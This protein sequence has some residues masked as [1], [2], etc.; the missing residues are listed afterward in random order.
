[1][2]ANVAED[3]LSVNE[4]VEVVVTATVLDL[5]RKNVWKPSGRHK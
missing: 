5:R 3:E 1:V 2:L 4:Q